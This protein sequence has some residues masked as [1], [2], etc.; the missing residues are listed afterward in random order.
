MRNI[1]FWDLLS[2]FSFNKI[3]QKG[4]HMRN[5]LFLVVLAS[6]FFFITGCTQL[7]AIQEK[8]DQMGA[9]SRLKAYSSVEDKQLVDTFYKLSEDGTTHSSTPAL[10]NEKIQFEKLDSTVIVFKKNMYSLNNMVEMRSRMNSYTYDSE[11]DALAKEYI[12]MAKDRGN[13]I[14]L[15][16]PAFTGRVNSIFKQYIMPLKQSEEWY[17][18]DVTLVEFDSNSRPVSILVRAHQA[19][20]SIG[21][22]SYMY[23]AIY[24]GATNMRHF[25]NNISNALLSEYL[26][27]EF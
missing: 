18:V 20:T 5:K 1:P 9:E 22:A 8:L 16:K 12:K 19:Q 14:K 25:E 27:R 6:I 24:F 15:F 3:K 13:N 26:I 7:S 10:L 4:T 23:P 21:V 11:N 17:S 2:I